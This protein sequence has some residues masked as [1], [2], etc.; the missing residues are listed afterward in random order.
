MLCDIEGLSY[1]EISAT[2]GIKLGTVRSRIHRGRAQLREALE[3]RAPGRRPSDEAGGVDVVRHLG[4]RLAALADG[5]LDHHQRDRALAHVAHCADCRADL[6]AQRAVKAL[7]A[8]AGTPRPGP[9]TVTALHDLALPGGPL[10]PRA[11]TM[12]QG[13]LVPDLPPPGRAPPQRPARQPPP[14]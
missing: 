3:H 8:A 12:P 1:E 2:L 14:G 6:D 10:P 7:L 4:D 9:D 5:E 11:R 13:A